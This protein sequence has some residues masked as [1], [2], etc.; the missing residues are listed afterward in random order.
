M[1]I[2][3]ENRLKSFLLSLENMKSQEEKVIECIK[4]GLIDP[5]SVSNFTGIKESSVRRAFS[6]LKKSGEIIA[7]STKRNLS[8]TRDITTYK[9]TELQT[10][11]F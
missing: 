5:E 8:D 6:D 4:N 11:L 2:E 10:Q 1:N 3:S 9:L 7:D